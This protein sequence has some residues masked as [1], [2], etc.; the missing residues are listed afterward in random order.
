VSDVSLFSSSLDEDHHKEGKSP[1]SSL[2]MGMV[3]QVPFEYM[4]LVCLGVMKKLLSAWILGKYSRLSKLSGRSISIISER[5]KIL[6]NY[7]PSD[8]ARRPTSIDTF[9]KFK[10]TE[11]RQ[12]LLYTGPVVLYNILDEQLYKHFLFLHAAIRVLVS[13]SPSRLHLKFAVC[14]TEICSPF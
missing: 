4:H 7:C 9:F 1:L 14:A 6:R 2:P 11:F 13:K 5:L 12:F 8:F 3:S 10:A